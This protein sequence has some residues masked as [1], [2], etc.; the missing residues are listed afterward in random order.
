M[1]PGDIIEQVNNHQVTQPRDV[2]A[3]VDQARKAGRKAVALLINRGG[4]EQFIAV[5]L[6]GDE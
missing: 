1:Q 2:T 3:Q 5:P 6:T 4:Q